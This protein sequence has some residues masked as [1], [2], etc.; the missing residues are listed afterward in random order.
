MEL[1]KKIGSGSYGA[2]F[3]VAF[4]GKECA[5]KFYEFETSSDI[6]KYC[7]EW[8]SLMCLRHPNIITYYTDCKHPNFVL[9]GLIMEKMQFN[10]LH[11]VTVLHKDLNPNSKTIILKH[12]ATGLEFLHSK[13]YVHRDLTAKNVLLNSEEEVKVADFGNAYIIDAKENTDYNT[14]YPGTHEYMPPEV[15]TCVYKCKPSIDIFAFGH[16]SLLVAIQVNPVP[17]LPKTVTRGDK[18]QM[19]C[20]VTRRGK[21]MMQLDTVHV[22]MKPLI[23]RCLHNDPEKR[24]NASDLVKD[25]CKMATSTGNEQGSH[26]GDDNSVDDIDSACA[27]SNTDS[28]RVSF[29]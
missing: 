14:P 5:A 24:P 9:P 16:L 17:H 3:E 19:N 29:N 1:G 25:L 22:N 13:K 10:L 4:Q 2:V 20:E 28:S 27:S 26:A 6:K 7:I 12:V 21:Y 11:Y 18:R 23:Y 8:S 15:G